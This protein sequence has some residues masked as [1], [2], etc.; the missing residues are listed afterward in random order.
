MVTDTFE[1]N[2]LMLLD[3]LLHDLAVRPTVP[4]GD[5]TA[6]LPAVPKPQSSRDL[7]ALDDLDSVVASMKD[8]D[9]PPLPRDVSTYNITLSSAP[10]GFNSSTTMSPGSM[11]SSKTPPAAQVTPT[12]ASTSKPLAPSL[13]SSKPGFGSAHSQLD[14]IINRPSL[15]SSNVKKQ[16]CDTCKRAIDTGYPIEALGLSFHPE[17]FQ[18]QNCQK[19]LSVA[20]FF[21]HEGRPWCE[22]CINDFVLPKCAYCKEA[23]KGVCI[24]GS[25]CMELGCVLTIALTMFNML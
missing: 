22:K 17:H 14:A 24:Q 4:T 5:R 21:E 6:S 9:S 13:P 19:Q 12:K 10:L 23:I 18:C 8:M 25:V 11:P 15:A 7:A 20:S 3:Q 1:F 2:F 16:T